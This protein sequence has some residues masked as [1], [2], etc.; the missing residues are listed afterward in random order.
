MHRF[1]ARFFVTPIYQARIWQARIWT[2]LMC[3]EP[4]WLAEAF[5]KRQW[6]KSYLMIKRYGPRSSGAD[7]L[8]R[9]T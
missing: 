2:G 6:P 4:F 9:T 3:V 1:E 8:V 5:E 7:L